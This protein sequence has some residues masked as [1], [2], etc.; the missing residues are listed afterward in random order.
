MTQQKGRDWSWNIFNNDIYLQFT[1]SLAKW[2]FTAGHRVMFYTCK[3]INEI[4]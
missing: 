2:K 3:L 4:V 1:Y